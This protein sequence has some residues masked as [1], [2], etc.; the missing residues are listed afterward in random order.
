VERLITKY[1]L[2][3]APISY[4]PLPTLV[5]KLEKRNPTNKADLGIVKQY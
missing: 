5:L 4:T 1:Y 3:N 2:N